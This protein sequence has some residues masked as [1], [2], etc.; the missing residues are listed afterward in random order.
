M[1]PSSE[2]EQGPGDRFL[3]GAVVQ[4]ADVGP[5]MAVLKVRVPGATWYVVIVAG[6]GVG[7]VG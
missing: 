1:L 6:R 5:R 2:G 3:G 7:V 4:R